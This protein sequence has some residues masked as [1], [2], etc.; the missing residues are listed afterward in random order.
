MIKISWLEMANPYFEQ[1][2]NAIWDCPSLDGSTAY[3]AHRIKTGIEK[4]N[5][6]IRALRI[7]ICG[8][9][10]KRGEDGKLL[11]DAQGNIIFE[12]PEQ[13]GP[14]LEAEFI[15]AFENNF[16]E[17]KVSK[18]DFQKLV[19][20]RGI[21]PRMWAH[22]SQIVENMPEEQVEESPAVSDE[23]PSKIEVVKSPKRKTKK[24]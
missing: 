2:V 11:N 18:L 6:D 7:E 3:T 16:M 4:A 9:Y 17:L 5:K 10:G 12:N 8:K 20:V 19:N 1:A 15:K 13:D 14:K 24:A 23:A 21:T 22:L